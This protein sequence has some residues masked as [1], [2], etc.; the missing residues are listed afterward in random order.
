MA[1]TTDVLFR[2]TDMVEVPPLDAIVGL[3]SQDLLSAMPDHVAI[4]DANGR[5][6]YLN[7]PLLQYSVATLLGQSLYA[8]VTPAAATRARR[9]LKQALV[10]GLRQSVELETRVW[11]QPFWFLCHFVPLADDASKLMI[12]A[13]PVTEYRQLLNALTLSQR[14]LDDHMRHTPLASISLDLD[15]RVVGWNPAAERLFGWSA[16]EALG[17]TPDALMLQSENNQRMRAEMAQVVTNRTSLV[18]TYVNRHRDGQAVHTRTFSTPIFDEHDSLIGV[19]TLIEDITEQS[20][21]FEELRYS[22]E[23]LRLHQERMPLA[24]VAWDMQGQVSDWNPAAERLFGW[25]RDEVVGKTYRDVLIAPENQTLVERDFSGIEQG[26]A[27]PESLVSELLRRDGSRLI[28]RSFNT[29][30]H[31]RDGQLLGMVSLI[32]DITEREQLL[33]ELDASRRQLVSQLHNTPLAAVVWDSQLRVREWNAAAEALYGYTRLEALGKTAFDLLIRPSDRKRVEQMAAKGFL[34][35]QIPEHGYYY[36]IAKDGRKIHTENFNTAIHDSTGRTIAI[37]S[38]ARDRT[39]ELQLQSALRQAKQEA[40][41]VARAK[42]EFLANMSHEIRTPLHGIIGAAE[43]LLTQELHPTVGEYAGI[44]HGSARSLLAIINDVLDFSKIE[45]GA[46]VLQSMPFQVASVLDAVHDMLLPLAQ[47]KQ[48]RFKVDATDVRHPCLQGDALRI[49]QILVNLVGNAIKFTGQGQVLLQASTRLQ[50]DGS[51]G[52]RIRVSDTGKGIAREKQDSIFADFTQLDGST[53]REFGGTGLG[54]A[55]S[56]K[57]AQLM[58]GHI[59]LDS[60]PGRGSDFYLILYLPAAAEIPM[61]NRMADVPRHYAA[62]VLIVDDNPINLVVGARL[63]A[64]LGLQVDSASSGEEALRHCEQT[65]Y[66]LIFMDIQMPV[67]SGVEAAHRIRARHAAVPIIAMTAN[68][69]DTVDASYQQA[70]INDFMAKPF[71]REDL[72]R[73]LERWL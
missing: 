6:L 9:S 29:V 1:A 70:G 37:A 23:L 46:L 67:M 54:L 36:V 21:L 3:S 38:L 19:T 34:Q 73:V 69:L 2:A 45:A 52:L 5:V 18:T 7:R 27:H 66:A 44:I 8:F 39:A 62:R 61:E 47:H 13:T 48:L 42:S 35:Q 55:I 32:E 72:S 50:A 24:Y 15:L 4:L 43:L 59:E 64:S 68:T 22:R 11:Q 60:E 20:K 14:R 16:A 26:R 31:D 30:L 53:E 71:R 17:K 10:T 56:R 49:Q 65:G 12:V 28:C 40:E 51:I 58:G 41:R 33:Q 57:L 25:T 63:M